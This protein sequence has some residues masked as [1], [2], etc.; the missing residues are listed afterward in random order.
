M[1]KNARNVVYYNCRTNKEQAMAKVLLLNADNEP[2][3]VTTWK[4][5][6]VLLIKGKAEYVKV[7]DSIENYIKVDETLVPRVIKLTYYLA[8]PYRELPFSRENIFIRDNYT[9][10]YCGKQFPASEL[11]LDHVFP[12]SR[13]GPD[14]WEN[15]A[16][17]CKECNQKKAD[18]TPKE[19]KMKLIRRPYR[20]DDYFEFEKKKC[21]VED[22]TA[23]FK[24]VEVS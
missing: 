18:R 8:V 12:K 19:A 21:S 13:L 6:L 16:T 15:I 10:Q 2:L 5:A 4:R 14:I 23:W 22:I 1:F 7:L 17:C 24:Y 11:T 20:P 9:C 3:N